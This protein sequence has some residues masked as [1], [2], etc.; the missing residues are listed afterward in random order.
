L[1]IRYHEMLLSPWLKQSKWNRLREPNYDFM[2]N[3][4]N[5][6][7][8]FSD[9]HP[10]YLPALKG[11]S[12]LITS[13]YSGAHKSSDFDVISILVSDFDLLYPWLRLRDAIRSMHLPNGR[14]MSY[15][16]LGDKFKQ[17]ALHPFLHAADFI[18]GLLF[19]VAI[20]K[21]IR[22]LVMKPG[23]LPD[24][25]DRFDLEATWDDYSFETMMR[26]AN[27]VTFAAAAICPQPKS[28][29]WFTDEDEFV[30]NPARL[31]DVTKMMAFFELVH[32]R[33]P[34]EFKFFQTI[35]PPEWFWP[36]KLLLEDLCAIP[37]LA[38]GMIS[39]QFTYI[40][41][42]N[43]L[44]PSDEARL[45]KASVDCIKSNEIGKWYAAN[46][47]A[48]K[49]LCCSFTPVDDPGYRFQVLLHAF[50]DIS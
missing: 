25:Q 12:L 7:G 35:T 30:A 38:A 13:D 28:V 22:P 18:P 27:F 46:Q 15:K 48:L 32:F 9:L 5:C 39:E 26:V 16:S 23:E 33:K 41:R 8:D 24:A 19:T 43:K 17:R 29:T 31:H 20:S 37:D 49:R 11:E 40:F 50:A 10:E 6:I 36:D 2:L 34:I 3:L 42:N 4:S 1:S 45:I 14:R 21:K 47:H 44:T